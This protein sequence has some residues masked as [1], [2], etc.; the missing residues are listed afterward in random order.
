MS[1]G[2]KGDGE[3]AREIAAP[4]LGLG[5]A[6]ALGGCVDMFTGAPPDAVAWSGTT[7][8]GNTEFPECGAFQFELGQ[9][10]PETFM[11]DFLV[12]GRAWPTQVPDTLDWSMGRAPTASGG[13]RAMS[14][15]PNSSS[16]RPSSTNSTH[17]GARP[18][19]VWRGSIDGDRMAL[20]ESGSPCNR[21]VVL[22][23]G[24]LRVEAGAPTT[25]PFVWTLP[26][27]LCLIS[28]SLRRSWGHVL[29][30]RRDAAYRPTD[31]GGVRYPRLRADRLK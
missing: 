27:A 30:I 15:R 28:R 25:S 11:W 10:R 17:F 29:V 19:S 31:N 5:A 26:D 16:S 13:S 24:L 14:P 18:Y 7:T 21:E 23:R 12:S 22:L 20:T 1:G 3:V 9:Y 4:L 8:A 6:L 2:S